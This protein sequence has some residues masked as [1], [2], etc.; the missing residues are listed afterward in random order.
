MPT[1]RTYD[2]TLTWTGNRGHG[3]SD[4]QGYDRA[5]EVAG[6]GLPVIPGS[7]DPDF[8]GDPARWNPE[9]LLVAAVAQCHLLSYLYLCSTNGVIVT[10]YADDAQGTM[11]ES[12]DGRRFTSVVLRPRVQV[13][14]PAMIQT[15]TILHE[16]AHSECFVC[17]SVS[18]PVRCQPA[19]LA[20]DA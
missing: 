10:G 2:I 16:A 1:V 8:L 5:N 13:A 12:G 4:Y 18:F 14:E 9:Q 15:A 7:A 17:N 6:A 20:G 3:T 11:T 19:V